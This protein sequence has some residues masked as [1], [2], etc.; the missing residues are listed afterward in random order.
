[1]PLITSPTRITSKSKTLIDNILCNQ[2]SNEVISGNLTVGISDHIP[3]FALI[4]SNK[5]TSNSGYKQQTKYMR[6]YK[7]INSEVF[8]KD[9]DKIDWNIDGMKDVDQ[10]G[11]NFFNVFNQILDVHAPEQKI[12]LSN[13]HN[14]HNAKPWI[15]K[16]IVKLM[17]KRDRTYQ[18]FIKE[19]NIQIKEDIHNKYRQI[20]NEITKQIRKSKKAY[21]DQYF[22]Q[23]SSN[24]KKLWAGINKITNRSNTSN[25]SPVCIEIDINGNLS[26]ITD[27]REIANEFNS[28]YTKV[29]EKILKKRKY[30]GNKTYQSYLKDRNSST[31]LMNPTSPSEIEKIINK[32]DTTKST[33]PNSIP[34]QLL[35]AVA[36]SISVPHTCPSVRV[37]VQLF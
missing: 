4:P 10:Y 24:M 29:A 12:K 21:Y 30:K 34:Q 19:T 31:F 27:P 5:P 6:N 15:T 7:K 18:K 28:H 32:F 8:N 1:M 36:K 37:N 16:D 20:R 22:T 25:N 3:Q 13:D 2:F 17:S 11:N 35:K 9:L 14:K 33:G 26:T 23:N